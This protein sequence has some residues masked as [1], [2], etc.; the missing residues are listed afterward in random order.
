MP[1][2]YPTKIILAMKS[3]N[4][5]AFPGCKES[6]TND[7]ENS[8]S[9]TVI[10]EA[11]HIYGEKPGAARYVESMTDEERNHVNNLIY[12]CPNHH[13][14]IDKQIEEYSAE[15]LIEIKTEHEEQ[16]REA[17]SDA[18]SEVGFSEL[19]Q[20]TEWITK[21]SPATETINFSVTE[22]DEK[23]QKNSLTEAS[24]STIV[25]ALS[26]ANEVRK[27]VEEEAKDDPSFPERLKAGFLTEYYRLINEGHKG[28]RLFDLMCAFAQKGFKDQ[29]K[30]SAGLAVL[31]YLFEACDVFEK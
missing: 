12:L 18:F 13:T 5:C 8:N 2:S 21:V 1:V 9:S 26:V 4:V 19:E 30:K 25:M 6:L 20:A 10:G 17:T 16:I 29:P 24:R 11:A 28:D 15:K 22:I 3:G 14:R 7:A 31:V 23:I 27:F